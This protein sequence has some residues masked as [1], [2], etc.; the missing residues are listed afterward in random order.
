[1]GDPSTTALAI[2]ILQIAEMGKKADA[3]MGMGQ[4]L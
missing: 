1:M 4:L 2:N 3:R